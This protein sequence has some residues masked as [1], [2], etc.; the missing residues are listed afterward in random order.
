MRVSVFSTA[1]VIALSSS[2]YAQTMPGEALLLLDVDKNQVVTAEEFSTQMDALFGAMDTDGD[3]QLESG[4]VGSFI[5]EDVFDA[6]DTNRNGRLS[7]SE[8]DIQTRK[9]FESA[10]RDGDG[11]LD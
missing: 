2:A 5:S 1:A 4:E 3:G 11:S 8:Y 6:A 10:D 9:D 7:K